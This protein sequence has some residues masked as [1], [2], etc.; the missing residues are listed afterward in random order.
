MLLGMALDARAL[1]I[2]RLRARYYPI[3][4]RP[5]WV[6]SILGVAPWAPEEGEAAIRRI[7]SSLAAQLDADRAAEQLR[8]GAPAIFRSASLGCSLSED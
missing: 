5:A 6:N 2:A 3:S 1:G 8:F 4:V 7:R